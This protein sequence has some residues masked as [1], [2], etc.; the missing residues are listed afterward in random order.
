MDLA[1]RL[2][3]SNLSDWIACG[4]FLLSAQLVLHTYRGGVGLEDVIR[5]FAPG[6]LLLG[7][8]LPGSALKRAHT[9]TSSPVER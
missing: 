2:G 3:A 5:G 1:N 4:R 8:V 6:L 7:A 9:D